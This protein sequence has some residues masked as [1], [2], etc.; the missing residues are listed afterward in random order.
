MNTRNSPRWAN[1]MFE[2]SAPAIIC[3]VV[4]RAYLR[5]Y[6]F[7]ETIGYLY[8]NLGFMLYALL[9]VGLLLTGVVAGVR[10]I[11]GERPSKVQVERGL[12]IAASLVIP[13]LF[14]F[15]M[16]YPFAHRWIILGVGFAVVF[17]C[18]LLFSVRWTRRMDEE[19][20]MRRADE[21]FNVNDDEDHKQFGI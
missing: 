18:L 20:R 11:R 1:L 9:L 16:W 12:I 4:V 14:T 6:N 8:V 5:G 19:T 21:L 15:V 3:V 2:F 13:A 10:V 17:S 7:T